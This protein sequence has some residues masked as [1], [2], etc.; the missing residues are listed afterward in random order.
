MGETADQVRATRAVAAAGRV[1]D[2]QAP[3]SAA[4]FEASGNQPE[5]IR[6]GIEETRDQMSRTIDA[7]Q[8]KLDPA[9]IAEKVKED[10]REKATEAFDTAKVTIL[11]ATEAT[12][13]KA[14]K[15]ITDASGA[16]S[17]ITH[18]ARKAVRYTSSP[19]LRYVR[20]NPAP[21]ALV[22]LNL[23]VLAWNGLR[24]GKSP[25]YGKI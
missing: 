13:E 5:Q 3:G 15:I 12:V 16:V 18:R 25:K 24:N 10:V 2:S 9:R 4:E 8:E 6:A 14:G 17:D 22:G 1:T 21:F 20:A 23:A 7:L 19:V 11:Q